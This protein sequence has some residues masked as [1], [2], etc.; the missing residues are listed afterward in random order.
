[1]MIAKLDKRR[2]LNEWFMIEAVNRSTNMFIWTE[3]IKILG[4]YGMAYSIT[5]KVTFGGNKRK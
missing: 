5:Y 3:C 2:K 4:I 1:M